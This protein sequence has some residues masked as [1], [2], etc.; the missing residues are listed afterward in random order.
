MSTKIEVITSESEHWYPSKLKKNVLYPSVT[1]VLSVYPKGV[2]FNKYLTAQ[3]SWESSQEILNNAGKRGTNVHK[4]SEALE[5]GETLLREHFTLE[6]WEMLMGFVAW[7]EEYQPKIIHIEESV[8]SDKLK[9]GGTIDRIYDIDGVITLLDIKTSSAIY[10]NYW[11]QVSA[12]AHM[13]ETVLKI[14]IDQ[15]AILRVTDRKKSRFEYKTHDQNEWKEDFKI[16]KPIQAIWNHMN[17][18]AGP[19]ILEVPTTLTLDLH[20]K[21]DISG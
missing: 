8:V 2:G 1:T 7:Y 10:G 5:R 18:K 16:F 17:P 4:A 14:K 11:I 21:K 6:E 13:A 19:K 9:T 15:T 12:Y 3:S 20:E